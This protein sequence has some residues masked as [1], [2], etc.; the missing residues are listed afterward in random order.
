MG[1][2]VKIQWNGIKFDIQKINLN[3]LKNH[4]YGTY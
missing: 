4:S 2:D 1:D 3:I